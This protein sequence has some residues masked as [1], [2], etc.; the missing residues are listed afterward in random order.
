MLLSLIPPSHMVVPN[1]VV[2]CHDLAKT[3]KSLF[4]ISF[5]FFSLL[6][7][8]SVGRYHVT[9]TESQRQDS[10]HR[11]V[12]SQ[13]TSHRVTSHSNSMWQRSQLTS[14]METMGVREHSHI[15]IVYI[16]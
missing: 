16:V 13:V 6:L 14:S 1:T 15:V 2:N 12:M 4:N 5:L 9:V 7:G 11:M 10:S 3:A 8:W